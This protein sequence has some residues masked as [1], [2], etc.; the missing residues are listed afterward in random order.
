MNPDFYEIPEGF[1]EIPQKQLRQLIDMIGGDAPNLTNA[2][3]L[4][5]EYEKAGIST[6]ILWDQRS[7]G[8]IIK[9]DTPPNEKQYN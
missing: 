4:C 7:Y 2:L 3:D 5:D 1:I 6:K 8:I 9:T